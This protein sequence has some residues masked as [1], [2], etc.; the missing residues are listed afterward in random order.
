MTKYLFL[1]LFFIFSSVIT[2][3]QKLTNE[4]EVDHFIK[5]Q[6]NQK[7]IA[8]AVVLVS[9][10]GETIMHSAY[11]HQ[12]L[13]DNIVMNTSSIFRIYSMTK[14][15][16]SL[17]AMML[18]ERDSI[19]LDDPIEM[20]LPELKNLMVLKGKGLVKSKSKIT[21]RDLLRH[22]SGFAYGI[23]LGNSKVDKLYNKNH[24]LF[25]RNN[26][27]M[28]QR[29]SELPLQSNPGEKYN[30]S[31]SVDVLGCIIERVSGMR[32]SEF[33]NENIFEPL[34]MNDTYFK[35]PESKV[36]RFCSYYKKGLKLKESYKS[37]RYTKDGRQSGGGGLVSTSSDYLKFCTLL[38]NNGIYNN[39]TLIS[40]SIIAEMTTNQLPEG[41]G[42]YKVNNDVGIGFGLGFMV[43]MKEWGKQGHLGDYGWS[44]AGSTHFY[45][46][47]KEDLIVIIMSQKAPYS[48]ELVSGL[49]PIIFEGL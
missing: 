4:S 3:A 16:T 24:P 21:V 19:A 30:Y 40:S 22:T 20:Y 23:G 37:T 31:I 27:Q 5:N 47:P 33:F 35:L 46:S 48:N 17:A 36:K 32:L 8:G 12:D 2:H 6:L 41:E 9:H 43:Y 11:G 38:L 42:V 7:N 45:I 25:V 49:K 44:G 13:D 26:K 14:P 10:N 29:L 28:V 1:V 39:D 34:E 18:I 15:V